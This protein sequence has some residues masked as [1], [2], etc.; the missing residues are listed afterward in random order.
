MEKVW[1]PITKVLGLAR[2][3]FY[4]R[5]GSVGL[6]HAYFWRFI[7]FQYI[8]SLSGPIT[9]EINRI[10]LVNIAK[11]VTCRWSAAAG[12]QLLHPGRKDRTIIT[13]ARWNGDDSN[14]LEAQFELKNSGTKTRSTG[15][16]TLEANSGGPGSHLEGILDPQWERMG[17]WG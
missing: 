17:S 12:V 16:V 14:I 2:L 9:P 11:P 15:K 4:R 3:F 7:G 10:L 8:F 6:Q 1:K 5:S 13:L